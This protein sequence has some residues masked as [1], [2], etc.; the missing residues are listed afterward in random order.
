MTK[1]KIHPYAFRVNA[2]NGHRDGLFLYD[3]ISGSFWNSQES[4][5]LSLQVCMSPF[6][7]LCVCMSQSVYVSAC[8]FLSFNFYG[9]FLFYFMCLYLSF[10]V[11]TYICFF[12]LPCLSLLT[13]VLNSCIFF[14]IFLSKW[15]RFPILTFQNSVIYISFKFKNFY[16]CII[17]STVSNI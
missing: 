1:N 9:C 4:L 2:E 12:S 17:L 6:P 13:I 14:I 16:S 3:D 7:C 15:K 11:H 8:V 10:F 5:H